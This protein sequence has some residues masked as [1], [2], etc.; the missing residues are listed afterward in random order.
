[1]VKGR[2]FLALWLYMS[3]TVALAC[4]AVFTSAV[5]S[6]GEVRQTVTSSTSS[7][8]GIQKTIWDGVYTREQAKRGQEMYKSTCGH[9]HGLD[10]DGGNEVS[11]EIAPALTGSIF[12]LRWGGPLFGLFSK[13]ASEMP[14]E[15]PGTLTSE[16][17]ADIVSYLLESSEAQPANVELT[18]VP[19]RLKVILVTQKPKG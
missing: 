5:L 9:C 16:S 13:I 11:G 12:L 17:V 14:K 10:L 8:Q 6:A 15:R 3:A 1:M 4:I 7:V 19:E 2:S 18:A